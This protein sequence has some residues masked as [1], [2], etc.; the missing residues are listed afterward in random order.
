[1]RIDGLIGR[2]FSKLYKDKYPG[3]GGG[4]VVRIQIR[5][6]PHLERPHGKMRTLLRPAR[7][8]LDKY[9]YPRL[10]FFIRFFMIAIIFLVFDVELIVIFPTPK[11]LLAL[12]LTLIGEIFHQLGLSS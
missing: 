4:A 6:D 8:G 10:P 2:F 11:K 1:M 12:K 7:E 9:K 5:T 3:R